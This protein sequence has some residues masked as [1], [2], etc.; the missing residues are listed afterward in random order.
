L[1]VML[2]GGSALS[3]SA[4]TTV[5][6]APADMQ[7]WVFLQETPTGSG[8]MVEGS[9]TAPLGT[10]SASLAVDSTGGYVLATLN[11]AGTRLA[12]ITA[13]SYSTYRTAGGLAL[14]IALQWD[15]DND[16]TDAD[17]TFKGRMVYEPY[18]TNTVL[19]GV[20]Q[21]WNPMTDGA[22]GNWWFTRAP[23][24]TVCSM[25][26]PCSWSEVLSQYPEAGIRAGTG[27]LLLKAGGGWAGGFDG[28][29]DALTLNDVAYDFELHLRP[30][31]KDDC[32]NGGWK[33]FSDPTFK[34][35]GDCIK[36]VNTGK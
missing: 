25:A 20:W 32:K 5:K 16:L 27:A 18:Y 17:T 30:Q 29:V 19:T 9:S 3:A 24:N 28:N 12:D 13:L 26:N 7:G 21:T 10:G 23:Y 35:Q 15:F 31:T 36:W 34:N 22:A 11:H 33:T 4:A 8:G 1:L 14:A 2:V 6:V